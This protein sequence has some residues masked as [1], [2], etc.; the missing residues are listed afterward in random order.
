MTDSYNA[1]RGLKSTVSGLAAR[2]DITGALIKTGE[3]TPEFRDNYEATFGAARE[4][5]A[6]R[7]SESPQD[8]RKADTPGD[9]SSPEPKA[10]PEALTGRVGGW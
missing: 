2:N 9:G 8:G 3:V 7:A 5:L 10:R 6:L 1:T 4:R